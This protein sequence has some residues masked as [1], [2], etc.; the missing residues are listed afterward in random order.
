MNVLWVPAHVGVP[1]NEAANTAAKQ[2]AK[3]VLETAPQRGQPL[4]TFAT[5]RGFL[6]QAQKQ[7]LQKLW[8]TTIN[9]KQGTQHLSRLRADVSMSPAFF[10]G[11]RQQQ[12]VLARLRFGTCNLNASK[13]MRYAHVAPECDCGQVETVSHF[14]LHCLRYANMR[15]V[16][17]SA[18]RTFWDGQINEEFLLGGSGVKLEAE[19]WELVI[20]SVMNFVQSTKRHI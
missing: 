7:Q 14:L 19:Q 18:I 10:I 8:L 3:R 4:I 12:T 15:T 16:M 5:S 11:T 1:G 6:K 13:S 20:S 2:A 17:F 9:E